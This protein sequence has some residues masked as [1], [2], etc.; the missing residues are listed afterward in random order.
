[1][2]SLMHTKRLPA[3]P[4]E[5]LGQQLDE[6]STYFIDKVD[7]IRRHLDNIENC[8]STRPDEP[9]GISSYVIVQAHNNRRDYQFG[10]QI[11]L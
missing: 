9:C 10:Q 5:H 1:M 8:V 7:I 6:F 2:V 11:K 4:S 3:L